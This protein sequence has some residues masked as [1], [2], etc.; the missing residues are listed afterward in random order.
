MVTLVVEVDAEGSVR[1]AAPEVARGY[2][3]DD[4]ASS[5]ARGLTFE[6]ANRPSLGRRSRERRLPAHRRVGRPGRVGDDG[7]AS[8]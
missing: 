2:G 7:L 6:P 5:A 1:N 8:G 3:F 4:A